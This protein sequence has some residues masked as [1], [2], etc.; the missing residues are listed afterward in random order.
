LIARDPAILDGEPV[1]RGTRV[2]VRTVAILARLYHTLDA[3]RAAYPMLSA[4]AINEALAYY[5]A[6]WQEIERLIAENEDGDAE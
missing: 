6:H 4:E 2:P 1:V 5:G 3:V